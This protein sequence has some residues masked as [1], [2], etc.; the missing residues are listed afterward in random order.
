MSISTSALGLSLAWRIFS[1]TAIT[2][3]VARQVIA[4]VLFEG[5]HVGRFPGPPVVIWLMI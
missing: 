4:L 1:M 5:A 3:P 2:G